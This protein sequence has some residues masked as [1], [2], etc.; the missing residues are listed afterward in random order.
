M[1]KKGGNERVWPRGYDG[2]SGRLE[3]ARERVTPAMTQIVEA[4]A[5]RLVTRRCQRECGG[6]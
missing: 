6:G 2:W 4:K 1:L 3:M 5:S